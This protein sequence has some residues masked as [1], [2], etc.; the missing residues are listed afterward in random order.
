VNGRTGMKYSIGVEVE[1]SLDGWDLDDIYGLKDTCEE[2]GALL[3]EFA[4][5]FDDLTVDPSCGYE[6]RTRVFESL[7]ELYDALLR[8]ND[9]WLADYLEPEKCC[10]GH[11][12][13]YVKGFTAKDYVRAI[14]RMYYY[15]DVMAWISLTNGTSGRGLHYRSPEPGIHGLLWKSGY[16]WYCTKYNAIRYYW[17][18]DP[19]RLEIRLFDTPCNPDQYVAGVALALI[20]T[21]GR[22][23]KKY[24]TKSELVKSVN[25]YIRLCSGK[26]DRV[27]RE[28]RRIRDKL[29]DLLDLNYELVHKISLRERFDIESLIWDAFENPAWR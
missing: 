4:W 23:R 22:I 2:E 29:A 27:E 9:S 12:H 5:I 14:K 28:E 13:M 8:L 17:A 21:M 6:L 1:T 18:G 24:W 16:E 26:F 25:A 10:G 3:K 20:L 11:C 7:R 15:L 19:T